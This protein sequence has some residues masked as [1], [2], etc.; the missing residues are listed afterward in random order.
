M[1]TILSPELLSEDAGTWSGTW[2]R[3]EHE[4]W[5]AFFERYARFVEH[6]ALL[7]DLTGTDVL[8]IG[9][10][11]APISMR[12]DKSRRIVAAEV[13]W[14]RDGWKRVISLA[15]AAFPGAL[16]YSAT[17]VEELDNIALYH[18]L[19]L[20]DLDFVGFQL[21]PTLEFDDPWDGRDAVSEIR[22]TLDVTLA[23]VG[24]VAVAEDKRVLF[25]QA[26]FSPDLHGAARILGSGTAS[27][28]WQA[29][30]FT[31]LAGSLKEWKQRDRLAGLFAWRAT[32]EDEADSIGAHDAV[33]ADPRVRAAVSGLLRSL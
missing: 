25:T 8:S 2:S 18:D 1:R 20:H 29:R 9:S 27:R 19:D 22:H 30:Q 10:G 24:R 31:L 4:Q 17:S 14:K 13:D 7:A 5:R 33:I 16:V 21:V 6:A 3:G 26:C 32:S 15:R 12:D 23:A 11:L 28:A